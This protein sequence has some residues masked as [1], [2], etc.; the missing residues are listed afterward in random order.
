MT[1]S[2]R[3]FLW[4]TITAT[5]GLAAVLVVP[6]MPLLSELPLPQTDVRAGAMIL[7][8]LAQ[9][10]QDV[11]ADARTWCRFL[12]TRNG[13]SVFGPN[14]F[15]SAGAFRWVAP[16]GGEAPIALDGLRNESDVDLQLR[17]V[18]RSPNGEMY[19]LSSLDGVPIP[20]DLS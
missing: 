2:R 7:D 15:L 11:A 8:L 1:W 5:G 14:T 6:S 3:H 10:P 19:Y 9:V 17:L 20:M 13:Q 12:L 18:I 4:A 16:L